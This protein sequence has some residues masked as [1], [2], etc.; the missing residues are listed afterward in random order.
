VTS[1]S[2]INGCCLSDCSTGIKK[3]GERG[4]SGGRGRGPA[5]EPWQRGVPRGG[6]WARR[7]QQAALRHAAPGPLT[8]P[9]PPAP[10]AAPAQAVAQG[11]FE[12]L[13]KIICK[14]P[15]T[16]KYRAGL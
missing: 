3:V 16:E 5:K 2:T 9:S 12:D 11:C 7:G 8:R 13:L 6:Q 10:A 14:E 1:L 15:K 4:G